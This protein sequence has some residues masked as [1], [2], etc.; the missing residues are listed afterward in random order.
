M[1][2]F[3]F[4]IFFI[5][6]CVTFI[7]NLR[8]TISEG[9]TVVNWQ[10]KAPIYCRNYVE[11]FTNEHSVLIMGIVALWVRVIV[12]TS[13]NTYLGKFL[14]VVKRLISEIF[15]FFA[16]Y[17]INLITFSLIAESALM[18][19]PEYNPMSEAFKTLFFSSFGTF[20]FDAIEQARLGPRFGI[21][22]LLIFLIINI[23]LFMSLFVS[24]ITV[25]FREF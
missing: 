24:I 6:I 5:N 16:L 1:D 21:S 14:G 12:L 10:D 3:I 15:L 2:A 20:D 7:S 9:P 23:G 4:V 13:Y 8:S 17:L 11:N 18:D 19:L 22:F 25:L